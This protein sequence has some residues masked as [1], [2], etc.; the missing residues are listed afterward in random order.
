[1]TAIMG[2]MAT[3]SGKKVSW[4]QALSSNLSLAD[5]ETLHTLDCPA[6]VQPTANGLYEIA[7]PGKTVAT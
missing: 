3:Y 6:P 2:R 5:V 1:L 7:V 4:N